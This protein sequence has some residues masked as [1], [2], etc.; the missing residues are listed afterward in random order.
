MKI[1][2]YQQVQNDLQ[3]QIISGKFENGDKFYTEAELTK[4]YNVSSI[5]VIRAVNELVKDGYLVRQQGKGTYV[6]RSRKGKLVEFSDIEVFPLEKDSVDVLSCEKGNNPRILEKL[7]LGKNAY[8]YKIIRVRSTDHTPYIYHQSYIPARYI[9]EPDAPLNHFQSIY[10][11]FKL[12]F[13]LHMSEELYSETN[14]VV[15]PTP[16]KV[17]KHL[18]L[19]DNEPSILQI[20]TTKRTGSEEVLEYIETYKH[21]QFFKFEIVAN[22][23]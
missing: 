18:N 11:R 15:F 21:W 7:K 12:D 9:K 17:A 22:K 4:L 1:P 13:H 16:V 23:H 10:H 19:T 6:S 14:Q 8:Y 2:K 5:T 20:R 3:Q